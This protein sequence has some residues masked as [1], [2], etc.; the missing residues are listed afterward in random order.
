MKPCP[1]HRLRPPL[2]NTCGSPIERWYTGDPNA[3]HNGTPVL[4]LRQFNRWIAVAANCDKRGAPSSARQLV[5]FQTPLQRG[6]LFDGASEAMGT[7]LATLA[8]ARASS[9]AITYKIC[10][11]GLTTGG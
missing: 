6:F 11:H 9:R 5:A 3:G 4:T 1:A 10:V 2:G 7:T 8:D